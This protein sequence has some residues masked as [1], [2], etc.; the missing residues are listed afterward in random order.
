MTT[1]KEVKD[2]QFDYNML[3]K[4][5]SLPNEQLWQTIRIIASQNGIALPSEAPPASELARL[6]EAMSNT[7]SPD[8]AQAMDIVNQYKRQSGN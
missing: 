3:Q 6:K 1:Y 4:L 5:I 8:I 7:K 2:M